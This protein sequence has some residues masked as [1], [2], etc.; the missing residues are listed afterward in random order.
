M[1]TRKGMARED[2]SP[3]DVD[4]EFVVLFSVINENQSPYLEHNLKTHADHHEDLPPVDTSDELF[5]ESNLMHSMNGYGLVL[6]PP[7]TLYT[8]H[9][10]ILT[11]HYPLYTLH[12][13]HC[14]HIIL[15]STLTHY[16]LLLAL[17]HYTLYILCSI[18]HDYGP[19]FVSHRFSSAHSVWKWPRFDLQNGRTGEVN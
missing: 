18:T 19:C 10:T 1:I 4:R 6:P 15:G 7:T 16:S 13:A 14:T 2:G 8:L 3:K 9:F 17:T 11:L 5:I 12:S